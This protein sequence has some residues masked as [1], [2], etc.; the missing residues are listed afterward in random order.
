MHC[1]E[2]VDYTIHRPHGSL[3]LFRF[4]ANQ[5]RISTK[6]LDSFILLVRGGTD[7]CDLSPKSLG[8][9]HSHMTQST[10][11]N[12]PDMQTRLVELKVLQRAVDRDTSTEKGG[13]CIERHVIRNTNS[14]V[15]INHHD[16]RV[17]T[18]CLRAIIVDGS[19]GQDHLWAV[20]L[21]ILGTTIT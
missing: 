14:K 16:V 7:N 6:T 3:H 2:S 15:L 12:N 20:I 9:F 1:R 17:T 11:S 18:V 4:T 5:E 19:I 21:L 10:K 8:K 13:S